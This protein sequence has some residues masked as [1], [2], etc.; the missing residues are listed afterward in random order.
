MVYFDGLYHLFYQYNPHDKVWGSMHWGHAVSKDMLHWEHR[1]IALKADPDDLGFIFSGS[2]VVDWN[3]TS[4]FQKGSVP[5]IVA[6]F[7]HH[8]KYDVQVQSLAFSVDGGTNWTMYDGNPVIEN[9]GIADFRDPKVIWDAR[10]DRWVM[11]L[12]AHDVIKFYTSSDLLSWRWL[13]DFGEGA[14]AHTGVWECPDL[15]ELPIEGSDEKRWVLLVSINPG[16]PNGGS[17]TQYFVGHLGE[18]EFVAEHTESLW[19]DYGPDN[20]ASVSWSDMPDGDGRSV[21]IGWMSNWDYANHVPT[22]PW[23]G[24]MTIPRELGLIR[25]Q[26]GIRLT[27]SPIR[28]VLSLRGRRLDVNSRLP[29]MLDIEIEVDLK[30]VES[31]MAKVGIHNS[32]GEGVELEFRFDE[33][34]LVAD[35]SAA[36]KGVENFP[37]FASEIE[38]PL[39]L[40][41]ERRVSI[42][43]L[44]D[45]SSLEV[46]MGDGRS[47]ATLIYFADAPLDQLRVSPGASA[48]AY[49]IESTWS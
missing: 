17:A 1:P 19:M 30:T 41:D 31:G 4:G 35:R 2:A 36:G 9:P 11:M 40:G 39:E 16:A 33:N 6:M 7:T 34:C 29:E 12:A 24:G 10:Y 20:Y 8:S 26:N 3:N 18:N 47:L 21:V 22:A 44:K 38:A 32:D 49:E 25:C 14:G 23:R 46:F 48:T 13:C 5:P 27:A 37:L 42:R 43:I 15:M 28:E 45:T